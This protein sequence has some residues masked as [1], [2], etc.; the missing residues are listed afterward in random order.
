[1][2]YTDHNL[3]LPHPELND[4]DFLALTAWEMD[5]SQDAPK[6]C[7]KTYHLNFIA[8]DPDNRWQIYH[9]QHMRGNLANYDGPVVCD[10]HEE[11]EYSVAYI[12]SVIA[13]ANEKGFLVTYN[14]PVWSL[15]DYT[16]YAGLKGLWGVEVYNNECYRQGYFDNSANAYHDL[17]NKGNRLVP[18]ATDDVHNISHAFGGWIM[19]GAE[20]LTYKAVIEALEKGDFYASTGPEIHSVTLEGK[21]LTVKCSDAQR[22][23]LITHGRMCSSVKAQ[24]GA[25]LTEAVLDLTRWFEEDPQLHSGDDF[26]RVTVVDAQGRTSYTRA[27]FRDELA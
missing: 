21:T 24:D 12:N 2:A 25:S 15:Q 18:L 26:F 20:K 11:R 6:C 10:G 19:V 22:I 5:A 17:L 3:C 4:E 16:D 27:F 23:N 9:P 13:R 1:M 7:R 8:K 14:H